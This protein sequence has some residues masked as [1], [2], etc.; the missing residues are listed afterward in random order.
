MKMKKYL[1]FTRTPVHE[2]TMASTTVSRLF[3]LNL[4]KFRS[5]G[6]GTGGKCFST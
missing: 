6:L 1:P 2:D 4:D 3:E 5:T